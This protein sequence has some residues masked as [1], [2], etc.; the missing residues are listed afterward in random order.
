MPACAKIKKGLDQLL[1]WH[2]IL[3]ESEV[4]RSQYLE[5]FKSSPPVDSRYAE[6]SDLLTHVL[7]SLEPNHFSNEK[8]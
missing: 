3:I 7:G 4:S 1:H 2:V 8:H 5:A 6:Y